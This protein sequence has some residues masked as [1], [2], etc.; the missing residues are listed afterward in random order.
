MKQSEF[1]FS[2]SDEDIDE[3]DRILVFGEPGI[4]K[5]KF[6]AD[7]PNCVIIDCESGTKQLKKRNGAK[8]N[9]IKNLVFDPKDGAGNWEKVMG[10]VE[11]VATAPHN[12]K[13][14]GIDTLDKIESWA[15]EYVKS[16]VGKTERNSSKV[17]PVK[18]LNQVGD[19]FGAGQLAVVEQFRHLIALLDQCNRRGMRVIVLAHSKIES[20]GTADGNDYTRWGMKVDKKVGAIFLESMDYVMHAH[21]PP[22]VSKKDD[23]KNAKT[24][25][26]GGKERYLFCGLSGARGTKSRV[27]MPD[28]IEL[29]FEE[30]AKAVAI[31]GDP[32]MFADKVRDI[33]ERQVED[34]KMKARMLRTLED[35]GDDVAQ[36]DALK[37]RIEVYLEDLNAPPAEEGEQG[38]EAAQS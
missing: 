22:A 29:S 27:P 28:K 16:R 34:A 20:V 4:G 33:I 30:F 26:R 9:R 21:A 12:F 3:P 10:A 24:V 7:A 15:I 14:V 25:T 38:E 19:G 32:K 13:T 35:C 37:G 11:F 6:A 23:S 18:S 17:T 1:N 36:M 2:F 5:T 8:I 31:G